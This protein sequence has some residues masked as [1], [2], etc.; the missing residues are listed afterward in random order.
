MPGENIGGLN[1]EINIKGNFDEVLDGIEARL[2]AL[3]K[4]GKAL[5]ASGGG[6]GTR[7][8]GGDA[9]ARRQ[10]A[11]ANQ[12]KVANAKILDLQEAQVSNAKALAAARREGVRQLDKEARSATVRAKAFSAQSKFSEKQLVDLGRLEK[13]RSR[14][15]RD[16]K[17]L[18]KQTGIGAA[19]IRQLLPQYQRLADFRERAVR[20]EE[21]AE[22]AD[23]NLQATQRNLAASKELAIKKAQINQLVKQQGISQRKAA[24]LV[25]V[26]SAQAKRLKLNM[27]DA[28]HAASQ[29]LFTF[30]RLVGILAI[31]TLARKLAQNIALAVNE[32]SRFNSEIETAEISIASIVASVGQVR[33][34]TGQLVTG[35]DAFAAS[36]SASQKILAQ[37]KKDAIGS[38]AT[39]EALVKSYQVAIGPGL[40]AGLDLDQIR[41][42]SKRLAEGAISLGVPLNQLSEEIR[43]L[44]QG[45]ATARNTRIAVLFGGAKEANEAIRNAK[46]Q[47]N[48]YEVLQEKL[49]GVGQGAEAAT[50][51]FNVL[52]SDL[53]DA[54]QLL[55]AEG[56]IEYFDQLKESLFALRGAL[57]QTSAEGGLIFTPEALGVVQEVAGVL[58]EVVSS[59]RELTDTGQVLVFIRNAVASIGDV[60][61]ALAPLVSGIFQG[62]IT[63]ANLALAPLRFIVDALRTLARALGLQRLNKALA[64]TVKYLIAGA[65]ALGIWN[66]TIKSTVLLKVFEK[67]V[68]NVKL[69]AFQFYRVVVAQALVQA[70]LLGIVAGTAQ[71]SL[72]LTGIALKMIAV[73]GGTTLLLAGISY[74][75]VRTG[76]LEALF[77]AFNREL[78]ETEKVAA[79]LDGFITSAGD[80]TAEGAKSAK[81]WTD[82]FR[83]LDRD[84]ATARGVRGLADGALDI[85]KL[86]QDMVDSLVQG[87]YQWEAQ[88]EAAQDVIDAA[89][90]ELKV[91][92]EQ[93]KQ[94][95]ENNKVRGP[96]VGLI[97][98]LG[99]LGISKKDER[100][101]ASVAAARLRAETVLREAKAEI[102]DITQKE[103]KALEK[104]TEILEQQRPLIVRRAEDALWATEQEQ[105]LFEVMSDRLNVS[106][107]EL[108][109]L[110][111]KNEVRRAEIDLARISRQE[112]IK[113]AQAGL[114]ANKAQRFEQTR[115]YAEQIGSLQKTRQE[116]T[117]ALSA[118]EEGSKEYDKQNKALKITN[119][120]IEANTEAH[121]EAVEATK[122][123]TRQEEEVGRLIDRNKQL[124]EDEK[125][126]LEEINDQEARREKLLAG[127]VTEAFRTGFEDFT[128]DLPAFG[129]QISEVIT[130][131][132]SDLAGVVGGVFKDAI[133][134]RTNADLATAFGEFFLDLA[135]Q[136]VEAITSQLI[137]SAI[138]NIG[139]GAVQ[140]TPKITSE[141]ANTAATTANTS[142][143]GLLNATMIAL[144]AS[145]TA[146]TTA[147]T[148][149][150]AF[151]KGGLVKGYASGGSVSDFARPASIPASDTVPAWL[152]PG[153]FVIKRDS[154]R[155]L[156]A[157]F[158]TALNNGVLNPNSFSA[159]GLALGGMVRGIQSF[160]NGGGVGRASQTGQSGAGQ[161]V[162]LPVI[163]ATENNM[164]QMITG[165]R[166]AFSGGV[167]KTS[168][169]GDPNRSGGW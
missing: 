107:R 81:E 83:K 85:N 36:L 54:V 10:L 114:A 161:T 93:E 108:G 136:F 109:A 150:G 152:T 56:G 63:G 5:K 159:T 105:E 137:A 74:L 103:I 149:G 62:L 151:A 29:F 119:A 145:I 98:G 139:L 24:A 77:G 144:N 128:R 13:L 39:F 19:R 89:E 79:R 70:E 133:D 153:E 123:I 135:G 43:S 59:F 156:G 16:E 32:I 102:A 115:Y 76:A 146:N 160:A 61:K 130:E 17:E 148:V 121:T 3:D 97:G 167:N 158:L 154:V 104:Q 15:V 7:G 157:G 12:L 73:A 124:R 116:Q 44:L 40:A 147:T 126:I 99:K 9:V 41:N 48:L 1:Y 110:K 25:G 42:I 68:F 106:V 100:E 47:G 101:Q 20:A 164:E 165:G 66:K 78:T 8:S 21:K 142:V 60:L 92:K 141:T 96:N 11:L 163:P 86:F 82:E 117:L 38:I 34:G 6:T 72:L 45:T 65:T 90:K 46:E 138:T 80:A 58:S 84:L 91:L 155:K 51:S 113:T 22:K 30:R 4:R 127:S 18:T 64:Q 122:A 26:T 2:N 33:D 140:D 52:K 166:Q 131:S 134:P 27:F 143:M 118:L 112:G 129:E 50:S 71:W 67:L 31:F 88:K 111:A 168:I 23:V 53:Q 28:Q 69:L 94:L 169:I 75:L 35:A 132:L 37:L 95:K 162:V 125:K 55:L 120:R 57:T 14:G 87:T 49:E